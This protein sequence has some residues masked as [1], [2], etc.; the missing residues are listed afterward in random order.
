MRPGFFGKAGLIEDDFRRAALLAQLEA[1]DRID[2]LA[3]LD[4]A[5]GLHYALARHQLDVAAFDVPAEAGK[6][7]AFLSI[8]FRRRASRKRAELF[9]FGE[10]VEHLVRARLDRDFLMDRLGH[11]NLLK[12]IARG[13]VPPK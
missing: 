2:A 8:D 10:R 11:G 13:R 5:P 7:A 12:G 3:P 4:R 6:A 1:D 9:C